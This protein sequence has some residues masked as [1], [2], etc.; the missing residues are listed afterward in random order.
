MEARNVNVE[1]EKRC[2]RNAEPEHEVNLNS[3]S[4]T[5]K[6]MMVPAGVRQSASLARNGGHTP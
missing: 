1:D 2:G 4:G 6:E 5:V 3:V